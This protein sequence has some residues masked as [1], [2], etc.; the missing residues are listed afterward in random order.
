MTKQNYTIR[1]AGEDRRD[2]KAG[3]AGRPDAGRSTRVI[4]L[5]IPIQLDATAKKAAFD[6]GE[7][8]SGFISRAMQSALNEIQSTKQPMKSSPKVKKAATQTPPS[9]SVSTPNPAPLPLRSR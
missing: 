1:I 2:G 5:S 8:Y 7:S 3:E 6:N 9:K 4:S